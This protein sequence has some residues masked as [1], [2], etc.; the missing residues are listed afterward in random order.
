MR[1]ACSRSPSPTRAPARS[2]PLERLPRFVEPASDADLGEVDLDS[3]SDLE[4]ATFVDLR[5]FTQDELDEALLIAVLTIEDDEWQARVV[6]H[7]LR[8]GADV[9]AGAVLA[10]AAANSDAAVRLMLAAGAPLNARW[11]GKPFSAHSDIGLH[12]LWLGI[13]TGTALHAAVQ[14]FCISSARLLLDA[15]ID[16]CIR[17]DSG[18][19]PAEYLVRYC[20]AFHTR[21]ALDLYE[22]FRALFAAHARWPSGGPCSLRRLWVQRF[23]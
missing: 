3:P 17:D 5:A 1:V 11:P 16:A 20:H 2:R 21:G 23:L 8:A 10:A 12:L 4:A 9:R 22:Q 18:R 6:P 7:L 15:G 19:T 13:A 14:S